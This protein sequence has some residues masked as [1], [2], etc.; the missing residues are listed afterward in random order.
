MYQMGQVEH[1]RVNNQL[2]FVAVVPRVEIM[3]EVMVVV[4]KDGV[5]RWIQS[6]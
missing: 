2:H 6:P 4:A 5:V 3:A 1:Q